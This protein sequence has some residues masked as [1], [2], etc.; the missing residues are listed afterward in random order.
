MASNY[1]L[2]QTFPF[3]ISSD[4]VISL[5][6]DCSQFKLTSDDRQVSRLFCF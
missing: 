6:H 2:V 4:I 1:H 3:N 5:K